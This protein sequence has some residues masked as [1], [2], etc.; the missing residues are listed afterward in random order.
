KL[1]DGIWLQAST[2]REREDISAA[3]PGCERIIVAPNI[4]ANLEAK[5]ASDA[6]RMKEKGRVRLVF[7]GRISPMKN[8][9]FALSVL[10]KVSVPV[11]Y[12]IIGPVE[13]EELWRRCQELIRRA[14]P[15]LTVRVRG[16][17]SQEEVR[18]IL[19]AADALF[20]PT[21]GENFGHAIVEA[22]SEGTPV[23][24]SN[25]TPWSGVTAAGAGF[26]L[27]LE[28]ENAFVRAIEALA[29]MDGEPWAAMSAAARR[30]TVAHFDYEAAA[31][32]NRA[33]YDKVLSAG[34][35]AHN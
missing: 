2:M 11:E 4:P 14:P 24:I 30:F 32:A 25:R 27:P 9:D 12:E 19:R 5:S 29:N 7:V 6:P 22:L 26:A 28:E 13:D 35:P 18:A 16:A 3:L 17:A 15:H 34:A 20:L 8:L 23:L 21:R 1:L 31:A 10:S 33:V